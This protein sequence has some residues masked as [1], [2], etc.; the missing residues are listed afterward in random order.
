MD[1]GKARFERYVALYALSYNLRCAAK[2]LLGNN[3][4]K[5]RLR[6][7]KREKERQ[8]KQAAKF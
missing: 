5:K 3:T 2:K 6:S 1:K 7:D 4:R 8:N